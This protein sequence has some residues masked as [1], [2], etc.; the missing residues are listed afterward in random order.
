MIG[1][2][3]MDSENERRDDPASPDATSTGNERHD[4]RDPNRIRIRSSEMEPIRRIRAI[5]RL[6]PAIGLSLLGAATVMLLGISS[7][8]AA[9]PKSLGLVAALL[10]ALGTLVTG[11]TTGRSV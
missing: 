4:R 9:L 2:H 7:P 10:L 11:A 8:D 6:Q 1:A 5:P 3:S